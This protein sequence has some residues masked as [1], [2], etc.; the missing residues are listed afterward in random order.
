M[1][2]E[3]VITLFKS[4]ELCQEIIQRGNVALP[5]FVNYETQWR[6]SKKCTKLTDKHLS[7]SLRTAVSRFRLLFLASHR[8]NTCQREEE[9]NAF[10]LNI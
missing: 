10:W 9:K 1:I 2:I 4:V 6:T 5:L 8:M 3:T 7:V